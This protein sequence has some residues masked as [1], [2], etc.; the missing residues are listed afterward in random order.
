MSA[1]GVAG[2]SGDW[3]EERLQKASYLEERRRKAMVIASL[4]KSELAAARRVADLGSGT[5]IIKMV[6]EEDFDKPLYG[7]ELTA[8]IIVAR[9]RT[10][11]ADILRLPVA[12]QTFDFLIMN[13]VYEHV[14][15]ARRLFAEAY[16][17]LEPGGRAYVSAGNRYAV[18]EPHYRLP[19]LSWLPERGAGAFLRLTGRGH[20]YDSIRYLSYGRLRAAMS[21]PG[22]R[23]RDMTRQAID[24]L[25]ARTWGES[26]GRVWGLLR[27]LPDR[28]VDGL[29]AALSP[30]WFFMLERPV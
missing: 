7:F 17:V 8:S 12:D 27:G 25:V 30:Q 11:Q 24:D 10:A 22:F 3:Y 9:E 6:L 21:E 1:A 29:L 23:V 5:G 20:R 13:H 28:A 14:P 26:W 4:C 18:M 19:F 15:D 16:R 2:R